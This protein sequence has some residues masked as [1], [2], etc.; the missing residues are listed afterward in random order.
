MTMDPLA[1]GRAAPIDEVTARMEAAFNA[2]DASALASLYA[3]TAVL[4]PPNQ[5]MVHGRVGIEAWFAEVLQ[6]LSHV[7][8]VALESAVAGDTAFQV[9]TFTSS[10]RAEA[11]ASVTGTTQTGKYVLLLERSGGRW[12][13]QYDTWNLDQPPANP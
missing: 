12:V 7:R 13:I 11:G 2:H 10:A 5:P 6:R 8:I 4:M 1:Q 9:G 3:D